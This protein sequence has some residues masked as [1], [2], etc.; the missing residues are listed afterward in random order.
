M[1]FSSPIEAEIATT[2]SFTLKGL[3]CYST[4]RVR[5]FLSVLL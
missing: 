4:K 2:L 3:S 5:V 1:F